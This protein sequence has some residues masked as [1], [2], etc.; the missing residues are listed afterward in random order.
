MELIARSWTEKIS[1]PSSYAIH[2]QTEF[3]A[4]C[5]HLSTAAFTDN[6]RRPAPWNSDFPP[7][8][9]VRRATAG[10]DARP[11]PG[12]L[13]HIRRLREL[14]GPGGAEP[15]SSVTSD[16]WHAG[17]ECLAGGWYVPV[18]WGGGAARNTEERGA[19]EWSACTTS[20]TQELSQQEEDRW[21][22]QSIHFIGEVP[23]QIRTLLWAAS[24]R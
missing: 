7:P 19:V 8:P 5:V 23:S 9:A 17:M 18:S 6:S 21:T 3:C 10:A 16:Q 15:V 20:R 2:R 4:H 14:H 11:T 12:V 22:E 1:T 13:W 24:G